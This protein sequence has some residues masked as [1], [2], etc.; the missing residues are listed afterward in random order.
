MKSLTTGEIAKLCDVHLRTVIR[1]IDNGE[2]K[3]YKLPGRGNNRVLV[4]DFIAFVKKHDMPLP[5][6]FETV[7]NRKILIVD[8]EL[9]IAKAIQRALRPHGFETSIATSGFEAGSQLTMEKPILMTLDLSMPGVDGFE[10]IRRV[11]ETPEIAKVKILVISALGDTQLQRAVEL[12]A[13]ATLSKPFENQQL[14][15][16]IYLLTGL[17]KPLEA[18]IQ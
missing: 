7:D 17:E 6:E 12:G 13:D 18:I 8:D 5:P 16:L 1:W 14:V 10:V 2:L 3:G 4:E 11:R 9:S 15:D